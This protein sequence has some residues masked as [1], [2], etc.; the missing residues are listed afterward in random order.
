MAIRQCGRR[1]S[2]RCAVGVDKQ[3]S[4]QDRAPSLRYDFAAPADW[5]GW[6]AARDMN[7]RGTKRSG[8]RLIRPIPTAMY[9]AVFWTRSGPK[10]RCVTWA[11]H[12]EFGLQN[13]SGTEAI[14]QLRA[15]YLSETETMSRFG[16]AREADAS[17]GRA[18][19][20]TPRSPV[21]F[22][23]CRAPTV[24]P[25]SCAQRAAARAAACL[26]LNGAAAADG[27]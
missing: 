9:R 21:S 23:R 22:E 27:I 11:I 13:E 14:L 5:P 8:A 15:D 1:S 19:R 18:Y 10:K 12:L 7:W 26:R 4:E 16:L 17:G 24:P 2:G 3:T 6:T 20:R 25:V